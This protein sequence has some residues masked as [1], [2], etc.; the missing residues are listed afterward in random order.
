MTCSLRA[1]VIVAVTLSL[2]ID[3]G[4]AAPEESKTRSD[5]TV[6]GNNTKISQ[7][8]KKFRADKK[9]DRGQSELGSQGE[10]AS[11]AMA[12]I[13]NPDL[14]AELE[15]AALRYEV[16]SLDHR[17]IVLEW[18]HTSGQI[19]FWIVV[20][21][22]LSGLFFSG[23]QFYLSVP[24]TRRAVD[25]DGDK[26]TQ[27]GEATQLEVSLTG[28]K[29]SSSVIGII[30]LTVSLVFFYLYLLH[31]YPVKEISGSPGKQMELPK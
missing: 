4:A 11:R 28:L 2:F 29:V 6:E 26:I 5:P 23:M 12:L 3:L 20:A 19:I 8:F 22:V 18:Q 9:L 16:T 21:I 1:A 25:A 30:I 24:Q 14:Q 17:R 15:N 27:D 13:T 10:G 31:V 7:E